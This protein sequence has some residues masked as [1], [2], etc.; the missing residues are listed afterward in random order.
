MGTDA[1][2][3][4]HG[5]QSKVLSRMPSKW[6]VRFLTGSVRKRDKDRALRLPNW[7]VLFSV[8]ILALLLVFSGCYLYNKTLDS[9]FAESKVFRDRVCLPAGL[10]RSSGCGQSA[11]R[12]PG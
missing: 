9:L 2:W 7:N 1:S 6:Q 11:L 4:L 3:T 10:H 8:Y 12:H 5:E